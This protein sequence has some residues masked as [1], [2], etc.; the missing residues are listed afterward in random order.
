MDYVAL[1]KFGVPGL[2]IG[3]LV[4]LLN[5]LISKGYRLKLDLGPDSKAKR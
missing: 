3:A 2:L 5:L 4:Y 1:A